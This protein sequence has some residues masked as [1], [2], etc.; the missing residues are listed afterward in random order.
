[1]QLQQVR[2]QQREGKQD[3]L[4]TKTLQSPSGLGA[5]VEVPPCTFWQQN[6]FAQTAASHP[7]LCNEYCR[8]AVAVALAWRRG[9]S[10]GN[11]VGRLNTLCPPDIFR[12][13]A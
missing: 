10:E 5:G 8:R 3:L 7:G 13:C 9:C 1:M 2:K 12:R 11:V 6:E 4:Q